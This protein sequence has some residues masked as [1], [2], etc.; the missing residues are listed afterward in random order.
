MASQPRAEGVEAGSGVES[1]EIG[2][3]PD[4]ETADVLGAC[5]RG[6]AV[7][8]GGAGDAMWSALGGGVAGLGA[9][10]APAG[11]AEG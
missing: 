11:R 2:E 3:A 7:A 4:A 9:A 6:A 10:A 8:L 5:D 1:V